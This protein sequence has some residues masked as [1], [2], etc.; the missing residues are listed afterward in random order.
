M[1]DRLA[2]TGKPRIRFKVTGD[3]NRDEVATGEA[4]PKETGS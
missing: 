2:P 3:G 1:R 4:L